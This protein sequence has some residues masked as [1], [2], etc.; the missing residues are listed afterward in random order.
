MVK[1]DPTNIQRG[2]R[3]LGVYFG[4]SWQII[5]FGVPAYFALLFAALFIVSVLF[6]DA[7]VGSSPWIIGLMSGFVVGPMGWLNTT[8]RTRGMNALRQAKLLREEDLWVERTADVVRSGPTI[9]MHPRLW[10][11][12][13]VICPCLLLCAALV[14]MIF[15]N[16]DARLFQIACTVGAILMGGVTALSLVNIHQPEVRLDDRGIFTCSTGLERKLVPWRDIARARFQSTMGLPKIGPFSLLDS[17]I[18]ELIS[19]EDS[20]GKLLLT[21]N[22][23]QFAGSPAIK[24]RFIAELVRRLSAGAPPDG[25]EN[26]DE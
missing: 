23:G 17:G 26:L 16:S 9:E 14:W 21:I 24:A 7:K 22:G 11:R 25:K 12:L 4:A 3:A 8:V 15:T 18:P 6:P 1:P 20:D 5:C 2:I 10:G 13:G 19:L